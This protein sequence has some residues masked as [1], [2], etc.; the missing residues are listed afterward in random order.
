MRKLIPTIAFLG[1]ALAAPAF[2]AERQLDPIFRV[3]PIQ[4]TPAQSCFED[5][6]G[7]IFVEG[8]TSVIGQSIIGGLL[9]ALIGDQ[10]GS[11][12]GNDLATG[13]GAVAGVA[14][15][16]WNAQR[17]EEERI[18]QCQQ[19]QSYAV[20]DQGAYQGNYGNAGTY[21]VGY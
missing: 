2:G 16:A 14:A 3:T 19:R 6:G 5:R 15:G 12:S 9:G 7:N 17:M 21:Q 18:R 10:F 1:A 11:G 20:G 4:G 8:A 13:I